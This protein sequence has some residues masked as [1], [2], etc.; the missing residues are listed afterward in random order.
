[1]P[2]VDEGILHAYLDG[3]LDAL[4][5]G[6]ALPDAMTPADVISHLDACADCRARLNIERD[7]R[8]QAGMV[9]RDAAPVVHAPPI[10]SLRTTRRA[11]AWVPYAWAASLMMAVGAGWWGSQLARDEMSTPALQSVAEEAAPPDA[12]TAQ[13]PAPPPAVPQLNRTVQPPQ[14]ERTLAEAGRGAAADMQSNAAANTVEKATSGFA[15]L[16]AAEAA[17]SRQDSVMGQ[18]LAVPPLQQ[19]PTQQ[20]AADASARAQASQG[21]AQRGAPVVAAA[22][23]PP[24]PPPPMADAS[25]ARFLN[26]LRTIN[27][28]ALSWRTVTPADSINAFGIDGAS[29]TQIEIARAPDVGDLVRVRQRL[30]DGRDV[31]LVQ[32]SQQNTMER[33]ER[34]QARMAAPANQVVDTRRLDDDTHQLVVRTADGSTLVTILVKGTDFQSLPQRLV[35]IER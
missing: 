2:H 22:P 15:A 6:G 5:E 7:I 24:A 17:R 31:E 12:L 19:T 21:I 3:A 30:A 25:V 32:W 11:A 9:L 4:H 16:G 29:R 14:P 1:M 20:A 28:Q 23:P 13:V 34:E 18:V 27:A 35:R 8:E 26:A 33:R 10:E